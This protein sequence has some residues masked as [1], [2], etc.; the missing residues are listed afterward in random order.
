[1][2]ITDP[3]DATKTITIYPPT[4]TAPVRESANYRWLNFG[5]GSNF[6]CAVRDDRTL[7]CWGDNL[8]KQLTS[9][10]TGPEIFIPR[11]AHSSPEWL[12]VTLGQR[13]GCAIREN[14][15]TFSRSALCWGEGAA[16]QYGNGNAWKIT[17]QPLSL[18]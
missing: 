13:H 11:Q 15:E 8:Y 5:T 4:V 3:N 1:M 18:E 7:W 17:P 9:E 6:S 2:T 10:I 12:Q 14:A 16:H